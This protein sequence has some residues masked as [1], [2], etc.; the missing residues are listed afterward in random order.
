[1]IAEPRSYI[2]QMTFSLPSTSCLLKLP[3]II[4]TKQ[5][6]YCIFFFFVRLGGMAKESFGSCRGALD[7]FLTH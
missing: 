6:V 4:H 2:F 5:A 1:M 3:I 7:Q